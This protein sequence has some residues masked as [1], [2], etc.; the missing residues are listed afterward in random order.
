MA[1]YQLL[2]GIRINSHRCQT[3]LEGSEGWTPIFL[4]RTTRINSH[5]SLTP[6]EGSLSEFPHFS[7]TTHWKALRI[8]PTDLLHLWKAFGMNSHTY[9]TPVEGFWD[10][11]P[12]ISETSG[13]SWDELTQFLTPVEGSRD[14]LPH[15]SDTRGRLSRWTP[16]VLWHQWKT[17]MI[18]SHISL[19]KV[20]GSLRMNSHSSLIL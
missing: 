15:F 14:E 10:K 18:N 3:P 6:V 20:K 2:V 4:L 19:T 7:C 8:N 17:L 5:R 13:S 11:L 12:Q 1:L 16:T 9:M